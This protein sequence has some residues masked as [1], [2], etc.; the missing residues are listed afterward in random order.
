MKN[1]WGRLVPLNYTLNLK[2]L[3]KNSCD[4]ENSKVFQRMKSSDKGPYQY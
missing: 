2:Y 3:F 1:K 4:D